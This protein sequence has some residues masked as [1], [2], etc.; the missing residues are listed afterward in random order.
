MVGTH[1]R[2]EF[3]LL[4]HVVH[5]EAV[6]RSHFTE[7]GAK[8]AQLERVVRGNR[9]VVRATGLRG[10]PAMGPTLASE[11]VSERPAQGLLQISGGKIARQL[12]AREN[13]SSSTR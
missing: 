1:R 10:E 7:D 3:E 12:H 8:R 9:Q 4:Q 6:V 5:G 2:S 11:L 13:T